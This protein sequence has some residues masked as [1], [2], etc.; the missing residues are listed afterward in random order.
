[1]GWL[2]DGWMD[3]GFVF[4]KKKIRE[5]VKIKRRRPVSCIIGVL[6]G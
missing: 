4:Q 5:K 3:G 2:K 1:M 6:G